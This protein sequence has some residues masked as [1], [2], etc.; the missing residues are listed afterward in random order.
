MLEASRVA[1]DQAIERVQLGMD[2]SDLG[3]ELQV[4]GIQFFHCVLQLGEAVHG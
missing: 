2:S 3:L 1:V 4:Q